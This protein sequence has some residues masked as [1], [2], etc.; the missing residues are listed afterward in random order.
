MIPFE[1][2][3][4]EPGSGISTPDGQSTTADEAYMVH[5]GMYSLAKLMGGLGRPVQE[6]VAHALGQNEGYE[7]VLCGHS[8]GAGVCS[9][10]GLVSSFLM[11]Q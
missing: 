10:L 8:L 1:P 2:A 3:K 11:R 5:Q 9:I 4:K 6:A 7:L